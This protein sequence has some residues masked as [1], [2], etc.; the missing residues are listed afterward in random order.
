MNV[1]G[2]LR[3]QA[4]RQLH[5]VGGSLPT[6]QNSEHADIWSMVLRQEK[7]YEA[8]DDEFIVQSAGTEHAVCYA[9]KNSDEALNEIED[10]AEAAQDVILY[11]WNPAFYCKKVPR[12]VTVRHIKSVFH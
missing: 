5:A 10:V 4:Q 6:I 2:K 12:N 11:A 7:R 1:I 3:A 8:F 9:A